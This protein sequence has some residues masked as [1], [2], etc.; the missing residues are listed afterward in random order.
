M[1]YKWPGLLDTQPAWCGGWLLTQI[2]TINGSSL[3][4]GSWHY[5]DI[6]FWTMRRTHVSKGCRKQPETAETSKPSLTYSTLYRL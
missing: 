6:I 4:L 2:R 3:Q 5:K 1:F